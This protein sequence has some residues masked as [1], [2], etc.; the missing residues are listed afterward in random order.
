MQS[1][2]SHRRIGLV[3]L[4]RWKMSLVWV[5]RPE[6]GRASLSELGKIDQSTPLSFGV[7]IPEM[8]MVDEMI[9]MTSPNWYLMPCSWLWQSV[10]VAGRELGI[11]LGKSFAGY[12]PIVSTLT[13]PLYFGVMP[14]QNPPSTEEQLC[15][16]WSQLLTVSNTHKHNH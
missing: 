13:L 6:L 7:S 3:G 16:W 9:S 14:S 12:F 10:S 8:R 11:A 2:T 5:R 4:G 15:W 1:V